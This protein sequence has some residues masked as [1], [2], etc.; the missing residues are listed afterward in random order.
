MKRVL[1]ALLVSAVLPDISLA[2]QSGGR[3]AADG[4]QY[5][6]WGDDVYVY[7]C[8]VYA[9]DRGGRQ[10]WV[11]FGFDPALSPDG[12]RIAYV[13]GD[14]SSGYFNPID[15]VVMDLRDRSVRNLTANDPVPASAPAWSR[16]GH[17]IAFQSRRSGTLEVYVM[18][19]DGTGPTQVTNGV[20]FLGRPSWSRDDRIAFECTGETGG[21]NLCSIR[22]D[23][24][25]FRRHT[26]SQYV[27]AEPAFSPDGTQIAF[28]TNRFG[29]PNTLAMLDADGTVTNLGG[30]TGNAP[31]WSPD[32][33]Q[34]AFYVVD[35]GV[36]CP[37]DGSF[38]QP[39]YASMYTMN[40]ADA[41]ASFLTGGANPSWA[42]SPTG[43][44][45]PDAVLTVACTLLTCTFDGS[46]SDDE[47]A[48][49]SYAWRFDDG[50]TA[51]DV[52]VLRTYPRG[53]SYTVELT[54][55]DAAG[56]RDT[57]TRTFDVTDSPPVASFTRECSGPTCR[58]DASS[59]SDSDG[60]V[61][62]YAWSFG[63]GTT[64]T[65][66]DAVVT[67]S[68]AP[69]TYTA[70]LTVS[71]NAGAVSGPTSAQ[72]IVVNTP[73]VASFGFFCDTL[74]P[75]C[76]FNGSASDPDGPIV[77]WTW[78]FGD[79]TQG[80]GQQVTHTYS[81]A[82]VYTVTLTV[83]D[84]YG[85]THTRA[86]SVTVFKLELHVGDL[87]AMKDVQRRY[88][89]VSVTVAIHDSDHRPF[90]ARVDGVWSTGEPGSC[91]VNG[92]GVC[93]VTTSVPTSRTSITFTVQNVS[94]GSAIYDAA[95]NHDIDGD[96][97]GTRI[98]VTRK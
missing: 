26:N 55:I 80:S 49:V 56:M 24:T 6:W 29:S 20:G 92:Y 82:G 37:A 4:C 9:F 5:D 45:P 72:I 83:T 32:G 36:A 8:H 75:V 88:W 23:G 33:R 43:G 50:T 21:Q 7:T 93:T 64:M 48:I 46:Q 14:A 69:G 52:S 54:V 58:F 59:S 30:W 57:Y 17:R 35:S 60:R 63:D 11:D 66:S 47:E 87:D 15:I 91:W 40:L 31:T 73:P 89:T 68:Y 44:F 77:N 18:N 67:H 13:T 61:V 51:T 97:N 38:C 10:V 90:S 53:G 22:S 25:G 96:T 28:V 39:G 2:Q 16:D 3:V 19:A 86:M 81:A 1:V 85:A 42:E 27:D 70:R 78:N 98:T 12:T 65:T 62:A 74:A 34:V 94:N 71:D 41:A 76:V 84:N 95:R 79:G